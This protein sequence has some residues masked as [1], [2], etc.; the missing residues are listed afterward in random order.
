MN[1]WK[2]VRK[3]IGQRPFVWLA[4]LLLALVA[5]G[6]E[7]GEELLG[8][9][10]AGD[11]NRITLPA[12]MLYQR[13]ATASHRK[14]RPHFVRLITLS[15]ADPPEVLADPC[16]KREFVAAVL[17]RLEPVHPA[18]V[19]IDFWYSPGICSKGENYSKTAALQDA[20]RKAS[21]QF[22]IVIALGSQTQEQLEL[23]RDAELEAFKGAGFTAM[24]Q[25]LD[26]HL[27]FEGTGVSYGLARLNCDTRR[28]PLFWFVYPNREAIR[29]RTSMIPQT[30]LAYE[31]ATKYDPHLRTAMKNVLDKDEHPFTSFVQETQ[32]DP[33]SAAKVVCGRSLRASED[34]KNCG[35][36]G[37][38]DLST[39]RGK[40]VVIGEAT[41]RDKHASVVGDVPGY[42]LHANYIE[43]LLD[44]R[45]FR[46]VY[47]VLEFV[48]T[49]L[50]IVAVVFLFD[51]SRSLLAGFLLSIGLVVA[52]ACVCSL[53]S[54]Y[55]G[56]ALVFWLPLTVVLLVELLSSARSRSK[57][58]GRLRSARKVTSA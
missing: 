25:V 13:F 57:P 47:P 11:C 50:G 37:P 38:S 43:S 58:G 36:P 31:A 1:I 10:G 39:L 40:V 48:L 7:S 5:V 35:A 23:N 28:I 16:N 44:D 34:W 19:V 22:P 8:L 29:S 20:V 41:E 21:I 9:V 52:V 30:S 33:I 32:F 56:F 2:E 26:P 4:Y 18:V 6:F 54:V 55:T 12:R 17:D 42:L 49:A 51:R 27:Q 24:D 45:Y 53:L 14:P 46:P 3:E 15:A